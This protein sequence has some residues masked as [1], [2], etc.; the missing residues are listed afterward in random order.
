[1]RIKFSRMNFESQ[2]AYDVINDRGFLISEMP[3]SDV[4][5]SIRNLDGPRSPRFGTVYSDMNAFAE[6]FRC[7]CGKYVGSQFEG[8][9]CPECHTPIE[10]KDVDMLYTAWINVSPYHI[11]SPLS[12]HRLQSALSKKVLE[13][14]IANDNIITSQ[15]IIRQHNEGIEIKKSL[16]MYHNIG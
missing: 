1:M 6:R 8:E 9:I 16:L 13:N 5:K 3:Y 11:I 7:K 2:C 14:I 15:G 12:Y 4:D 10:F